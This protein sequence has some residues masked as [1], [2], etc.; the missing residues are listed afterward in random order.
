MVL[1]PTGEFTMGGKVEEVADHPNSG[2]FFFL[3]ERPL[4]Q[5]EISSFYLDKYEVTNDLYEKF[6]KHVETTGDTTMNHVGQPAA[7][8]HRPK[9][10][11]EEL[12]GKSQPVVGVNWYDAYAYCN[13]SG[14]RL[15]TAAEWEY[16]AR[17]SKYRTYPWGD[18][19]PDAGGEWRANYKPEKGAA[20]DGYGQTAP[21]GSYL[22]G[23]S[24]FGIA[25][26]SG[27][28]EEWV[29]DWTDPRYYTKQP[30]LAID[31][32]GP[33]EGDIRGIKGGSFFSKRHYIRIGTRL[34]GVPSGRAIYLG[35]R[36]AESVETDES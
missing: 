1:I 4:H 21:A 22:K 33:E 28:V 15:P 2:S 18:E 24:P 3:S 6:L 25:D 5:V 12:M 13:W 26:M 23:L 35:F 17:G 16:A 34:Y 11:S 19:A 20:L 27:N 8:D 10:V 31:P 7:T 36:C 30:D 9:E 29:Q 14:K 32:Q